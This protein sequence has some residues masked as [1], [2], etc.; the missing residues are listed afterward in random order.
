MYYVDECIKNTKR[1]F[2]EQGREGYMRLDMNENPEGLPE[3]VVN[4]I[5]EAVT[6]EFLSRYPEQRPFIEKYANFM[7]LNTNQ[8]CLTNGSDNAIRYILQTFAQKG[9]D[10]LT[11]S[12]T[13][14]MYMVNC[15]LLGLNHK[16]VPYGSDLKVDVEALIDAID[17]NTDIVALVN[18]NNPLGD[19]YAKEDAR[20]IAMTAQEH[21]AI[22]LIDE[23]YHYFTDFTLLDLVDEFDNVLLLRTFSKCLSLAGVRLGIIIGNPTIVGY[24]NNLRVS[25]EV[26]TFAL[27]CGEIVLD[28]P[29]LIDY[30]ADVQIK[31]R[32]YLISELRA[33]GYEVVPSETNF[34]SFKPK[35]SAETLD[36]RLREKKI[37]VHT[38]GSG[39]LQGWVRVNTGS[40]ELLS[41]FMEALLDSDRL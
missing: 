32:E 34:I 36:Q 22:V 2:P 14:E 26:N 4:K 20:R 29:G 37:L 23:A 9:K 13:F 16:T 27:K 35:T 5:R 39:P 40:V 33:N 21:N 7:G 12:P 19:V 11:V 3:S 6:P 25:F 15:W 10:V 41:K 30:L 31:G 38:F 18:P 28:T 8:I 17:D 24:V 1:I